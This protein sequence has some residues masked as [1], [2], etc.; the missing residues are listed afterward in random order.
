MKIVLD[1][2]QPLPAGGTVQ[3]IGQQEEFPIA[4]QGNVY[5]TGLATDNHLRVLWHEQSCELEVSFPETEEPLPD[6]GTF[7]CHGVAH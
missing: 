1:N 4:L 2:G 7:T 5:I 6:L 3:I